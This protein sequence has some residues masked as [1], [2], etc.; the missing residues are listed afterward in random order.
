VV[1][2]GNTAPAATGTVAK[3][4]GFTTTKAIIAGVVVVGGAAIVVGVVKADSKSTIS[5]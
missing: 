1:A 5:Q 2:A 4:G 3:T